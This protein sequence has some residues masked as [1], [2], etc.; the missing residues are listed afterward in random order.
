MTQPH[1]KAGL[2]KAAEELYRLS[3]AVS[4][5]LRDAGASPRDPAL[6]DAVVRLQLGVSL[7]AGTLVQGSHIC[8]QC[9]QQRLD[10]QWGSK[11]DYLCTVCLA[12]A[13]AA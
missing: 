11:H 3:D 5:L 9:A 6:V 2:H 7:V 1:D 8:R 4:A 13:L 10:A 12:A